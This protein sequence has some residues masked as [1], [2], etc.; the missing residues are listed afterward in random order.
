MMWKVREVQRKNSK[1]FIPAR[2]G[3]EVYRHKD[4]SFVVLEFKC[5]GGRYKEAFRIEELH[6][7]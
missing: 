1:D 6:A 7:V 5:A 4:N 3:K 2:V